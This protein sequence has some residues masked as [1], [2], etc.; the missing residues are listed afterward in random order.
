MPTARQLLIHTLKSLGYIGDLRQGKLSDLK[1]F[2]QRYNH[3]NKLGFNHAQWDN[4]S[5]HQYMS[6]K[7]QQLHRRLKRAFAAIR[8]LIELKPTNNLLSAGVASQHD[9]TFLPNTWFSQSV[10]ALHRR[11]KSAFTAIRFLIK[12]KHTN[13]LLSA[14]V[15]S[16][17][18][19][20]FL[21]NTWFSQSVSASYPFSVKIELNCTINKTYLFPSD[22]DSV[23]DT[24]H[25][26]HEFIAFKLKFAKSQQDHVQV[27]DLPAICQALNLDLTVYTLDSNLNS[28]KLYKSGIQG[29]PICLHLDQVKNHYMI[30]RTLLHR[31]LKSAFTAIRFLIK[32]KHTNNLLSAVCISSNANMLKNKFCSAYFTGVIPLLCH[33]IKISLTKHINDLNNTIQSWI[34]NSFQMMIQCLIQNI[35]Y[36]NSLLSDLRWPNHS[37]ILRTISASGGVLLLLC[38]N[39]L[40]SK[41]AIAL[42]DQ[43]FKQCHAIKISLTKHINDLNNTI[44]SW[45]NNSFTDDDSVPDTKHRIHEF[46]A[47]KLKFAKSQQDHVQVADLP[48]ICQALNL[49]LTVY[50][51]D[52]N[53]NSVKNHYMLLRTLVGYAETVICD[54]CKKVFAYSNSSKY[55]KHMAKHQKDQN[56]NKVLVFKDKP[57]QSSSTQYKQAFGTELVRPLFL[58]YDFECILKKMKQSGERDQKT[59]Y[60]IVMSL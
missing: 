10:S 25:R 7:R 14:G 48:A 27:A 15:A 22:D 36:M 17:H 58:A 59:T 11:L 1:E 28:V 46:I 49:D 52:S 55:H 8:F 45:I 50:T 2:I 24:K 39:F 57:I 40:V 35:E 19:Y 9:Y 42:R 21:P 43:Y 23:P 3:A 54:K 4:Q 16:Q 13:N 12:L 20:T 6:N 33:A 41:L 29:S 56:S 38:M 31:R 51:L 18:D 47:F 53:L 32:L 30:L 37:K 34:N 5:L 26:I 44:Q 60:T